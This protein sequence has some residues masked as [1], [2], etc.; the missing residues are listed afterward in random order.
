MD[1]IADR[2]CGLGCRVSTAPVF[3]VDRMGKVVFANRAMSDSCG[4]TP[5]SILGSSATDFLVNPS[6]MD[7]LFALKGRAILAL[8]RL[9]GETMQVSSHVT[10]L[11]P[12]V[13]SLV[14]L[15][16]DDA[17]VPPFAFVVVFPGGQDAGN[18]GSGSATSANSS[19][20]CRH[21]LLNAVSPVK[22]AADAF[23][24]VLRGTPGPANWH[25]RDLELIRGLAEALE[26]SADQLE[27]TILDLFPR[28]VPEAL[29]S[30]TW[31]Q[32]GLT[33]S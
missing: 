24:Q 23:L 11:P 9:G 3:C 27:G 15:E 1:D 26:M 10:I 31:D 16:T 19:T 32:L 8:K 4:Q 30:S 25:A 22:T 18:A 29:D 33:E 7:A 20:H 21:A 2:I 6:S 14:I 5:E 12:S 13:L 17:F 28:P